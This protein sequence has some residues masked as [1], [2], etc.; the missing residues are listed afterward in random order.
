[1]KL[2]RRWVVE[3]TFAWLGRY[4]RNSRHYE[5]R[6]ESGEAMLTISSIHRMTR[7]LRPDPLK[8]Q[9]AFKYRESLGKVTG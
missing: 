4:R 2:P 9:A 5:L 6:P 3:R 8:R 7:F 1:M